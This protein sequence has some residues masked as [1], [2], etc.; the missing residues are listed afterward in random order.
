MAIRYNRPPRSARNNV[1]TNPEP[2]LSEVV[3][4]NSVRRNNRNQVNR[5]LKLTRKIYGNSSPQAINSFLLWDFESPDGNEVVEYT[6]NFSGRLE[7]RDFGDG[8]LDLTMESGQKITKEY[9]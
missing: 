9:S 4:L 1:K 8:S 5:S 3:S 7:V 2:E 6:F